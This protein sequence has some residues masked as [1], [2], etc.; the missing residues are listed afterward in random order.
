FDSPTGLA[1]DAAGNIY[2]ADRSNHQ[3]KK[4]SPT[5][6]FIGSWG[7][8]GNGNGQ[9]NSPSDVAVDATGNAY[10][11]D[12]GN[13][14]SQNFA[15]AG[16]LLFQWNQLSPS[17]IAVDADGFLYVT[18]APHCRIAKLSPAGNVVTRWGTC[19]NNVGGGFDNPSGIVVDAFGSVSVADRGNH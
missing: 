10:V 19:G 14:R 13:S 8:L 3:V 6:A 2:V 17:G 16:A 5:G 12:P 18:A 4:F 7:T 15:S 1:T 9:F 11:S